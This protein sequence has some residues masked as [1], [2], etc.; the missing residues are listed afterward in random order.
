VQVFAMENRYDLVPQLDSAANPDQPD[1]TAVTFDAQKGTVGDNNNLGATYAPAAKDL[2]ANNPFYAAWLR[3][4]QGF[5]DST[6]KSSTST[7]Q[8]TSGPGS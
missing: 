8:I 7:Y 6:S 4:A 3:T 5:L 2:P 1:L